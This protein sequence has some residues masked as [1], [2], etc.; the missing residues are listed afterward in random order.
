MSV[1]KVQQE[2]NN[3]GRRLLAG[4]IDFLFAF[5]LACL[6][7]YLLRELLFSLDVRSLGYGSPLIFCFGFMILA[8]GF[9]E[10]MMTKKYQA[11]LGKQVLGI[12]IV[13]GVGSAVSWK[14]SAARFFSKL[15]H[16]GILLA[17]TVP[18]PGPIS[19][20]VS[21]SGSWICL[22]TP[23]RQ[24]LHDMIAK[25]YVVKGSV[26]NPI[27]QNMGR[28]IGA[29]SIDFILL[30]VPLL[31]IWYCFPALLLWSGQSPVYIGSLSGFLSTPLGIIFMILS[32]TYGTVMIKLYQG[33]VG[34]ILCKVKI[35]TMT[36]KALTWQ[37][38]AARCL[39]QQ[40]H[41]LLFGGLTYIL[42]ESRFQEWANNLQKLLSGDTTFNDPIV[43]RTM[44]M[45]TLFRLLGNVLTNCG[46]SLLGDWVCLFNKKRQTLHDMIAGTVVVRR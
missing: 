15:A 4:C 18:L 36:G 38:S 11:T 17:V 3:F 34:K 22:F 2:Y 31:V 21:L 39:L 8:W 25:T 23:K 45:F 33:T 35:T 37:R 9:H 5:V 30:S 12:M 41:I 46:L 24:A 43:L 7:T 1:E 29:A 10:V 40:G 19:W 6:L 13:N 32:L 28:R 42:M 26:L 16:T 27:Y 44:V 20:I 14:Q